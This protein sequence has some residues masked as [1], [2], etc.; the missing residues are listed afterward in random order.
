MLRTHAIAMSRSDARERVAY[1]EVIFA[2]YPPCLFELCG[3]LEFPTAQ[4]AAWRDERHIE[5][6]THRENVAFGG[7]VR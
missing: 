7:A 2:R 6:F 5:E 1:I 4:Y 3:R